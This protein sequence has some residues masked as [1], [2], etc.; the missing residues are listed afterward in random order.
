MQRL[1]QLIDP[2]NPIDCVHQITINSLCQN[3]DLQV[4]VKIPIPE[5][6][7]PASI[8]VIDTTNVIPIVDVLY[9][10]HPHCA[11]RS[12]SSVV[13]TNSNCATTSS[14]GSS[15]QDWEKFTEFQSTG[16]RVS[17]LGNLLLQHRCE[18][19]IY[20]RLRPVHHPLVLQTELLNVISCTVN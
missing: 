1:H 5:R 13:A 7:R 12:L 19:I 16:T 3:R 14:T 10:I 20:E 6:P 8:P 18:D 15:R 17:G 2:V 4:F 9:C 11:P